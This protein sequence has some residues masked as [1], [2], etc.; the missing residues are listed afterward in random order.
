MD[1]G[2]WRSGHGQLFVELYTLLMRRCIEHRMSQVSFSVIAS[3]CL[4]LV[5]KYIYII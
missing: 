2:S 3:S 1:N 4:K 5:I